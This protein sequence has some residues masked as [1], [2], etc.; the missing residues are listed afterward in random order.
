MLL[1][2]LSPNMVTKRITVDGTNWVGA[3]GL[4][5]LTSEIIDTRGF[6]GVRF[7]ISLGAIVA[8]ALTSVKVQQGA[9]SN[10]SDA[11]DIAGYWNDHCG[12][13]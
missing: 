13:R 2:N 3:A 1:H 4:T 8:G 7:I 11:A 9:V 5:A 6:H 10:M 12:Y